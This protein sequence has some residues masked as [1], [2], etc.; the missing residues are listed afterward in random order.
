MNIHADV[1]YQL[2]E[3]LCVYAVNIKRTYVMRLL[4]ETKMA[5]TS[6]QT[7]LSHALCLGVCM[8]RT[9]HSSPH[10]ESGDV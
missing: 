8:R 3:S 1:M 4:N 9:E 2:E 5:H 10:T 7:H 6:A